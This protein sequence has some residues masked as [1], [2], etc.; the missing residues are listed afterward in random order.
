MLLKLCAKY[1]VV[2]KKMTAPG[3]GR[4]GL[5]SGDIL[6]ISPGCFKGVVTPFV[7]TFF[8]RFLLLMLLYGKNNDSIEKGKNLSIS[9]FKNFYTLINVMLLKSPFVFFNNY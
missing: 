5:R 1:C 2:L 8:R 3:G 4:N 6:W 7:G 9:K